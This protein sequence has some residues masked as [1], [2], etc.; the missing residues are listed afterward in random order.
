MSRLLS[1]NP[2]VSEHYYAAENNHLPNKLPTRTLVQFTQVASNYF[3]I[4]QTTCASVQ[5]LFNQLDVFLIHLK[6]TIIRSTDI[7][8]KYSRSDN[9]QPVGFKI[10]RRKFQCR[11]FRI[12]Q[13][14]HQFTGVV[15]P[16]MVAWKGSQ[17]VAAANRHK[18]LRRSSGGGRS[19]TR[20]SSWGSLFLEGRRWTPVKCLVL[21]TNTW[22]FCRPK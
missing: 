22:S 2:L 14:L 5:I 3:L 6:T 8:K 4:L 13:W 10:V 12:F 1:P 21:L 9:W 7:S 11:H 17:Q 19:Q 18:A 16:V 15:L 20:L